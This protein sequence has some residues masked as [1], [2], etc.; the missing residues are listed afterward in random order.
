MGTHTRR[1]K[2]VTMMALAV[3]AL[4][5]VSQVSSLAIKAQFDVDGTGSDLIDKF[6]D[7][8]GDYLDMRAGGPGQTVSAAASGLLTGSSST[9]S[10]S[11]S[12]GKKGATQGAN[13]A[14]E[15]DFVRQFEEIV[16]ETADFAEDGAKELSK[17]LDDDEAPKAHGKKHHK[18]K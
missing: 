9:G 15:E 18:K 7:F 1:M 2:T 10:K 5:L 6:E 3:C 12:S 8:A 13:I 11:K 16:D 14:L 17:L 4:A